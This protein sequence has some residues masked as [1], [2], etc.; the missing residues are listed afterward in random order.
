LGSH[1]DSHV[2]VGVDYEVAREVKADPVE[3]SGEGERILVLVWCDTAS[4]V[5][6]AGEGL[7]C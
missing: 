2:G 3:G 1:G 4:G 6:A 7:R 5:V